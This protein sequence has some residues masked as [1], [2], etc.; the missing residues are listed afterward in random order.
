MHLFTGQRPL[1]NPKLLPAT[2]HSQP[3]TSH[4]L[5]LTPQTCFPAYT[6]AAHADEWP[7]M[8]FGDQWIIYTHMPLII[9]GPSLNKLLHCSP[10]K[11]SSVSQSAT[12]R[13]F[14]H[15]PTWIWWWHFCKMLNLRHNSIILKE[16]ESC[17]SS[18]CSWDTRNRL[19]FVLFLIQFV[20]CASFVN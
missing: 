9:Q 5:T 3:P 12:R 20:K 7:V 2:S 13:L 11:Q 18:F 1:H 6:T 8:L 10:N 19:F 15:Y 17:L 4:L 14:I 16:R